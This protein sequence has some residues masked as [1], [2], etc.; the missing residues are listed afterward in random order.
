MVPF[1]VV[2]TVGTV[3]GGHGH[4]L[5]E[6]GE[7]H[8][9]LAF[10]APGD[11]GE[12]VVAPHDLLGDERGPHLA[13]G[14]GGLRCA[15][16]EHHQLKLLHVQGVHRHLKEG[17]AAVYHVV[18]REGAHKEQVVLPHVHREV[19]VHLVHDDGLPVRRVGGPQQLAVDL[20]PDHQGLPHVGHA[21]RQAQGALLGTNYGHVTEG[22]G[23]GPL[24]RQ[25]D[26]GQDDAAHEAVDNGSDQGL[27]DDEGDSTWAKRGDG[28]PAVANGG[29]RFEGVEE[30]RGEAVHI[31]HA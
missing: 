27:D 8:F 25:G 18:E 2:E 1:D 30:R 24:F 22:D 31:V 23:F 6:V 4:D 12:E 21:D 29:L 10:F 3:C 16:Q 26:F 13:R 17:A 14:A 15:I 19:D 5:G 11:D 28:A 20:A 7:V 9:V